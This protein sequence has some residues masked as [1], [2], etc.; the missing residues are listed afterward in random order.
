MVVW[1]WLHFKYKIL[2][3]LLTPKQLDIAVTTRFA[4]MR[5]ARHD[6]GYEPI[7]STADGI[8]SC[9]EY[10]KKRLPEIIAQQ[11]GAK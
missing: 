4:S 1:E 11:K 5:D 10:Y 8:A 3:P 6:F 2:P 9:I 7:V